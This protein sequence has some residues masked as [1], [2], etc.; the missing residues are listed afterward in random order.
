M[1]SGALLNFMRTGDP[2][3]GELPVW[4]KYTEENGEVMILN[5]T[6][7]ARNDPDREARKSLE[8]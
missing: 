2:N 4:P 6:C 8:V 3:G 7:E 1:M 5:N